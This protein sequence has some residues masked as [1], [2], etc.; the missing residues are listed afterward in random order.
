VQSEEGKG[1]SFAVRLPRGGAVANGSDEN[2][3]G[4][5]DGAAQSARIHSLC[6]SGL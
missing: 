1:S 5:G 6:Q 3:S 2:G 4:S